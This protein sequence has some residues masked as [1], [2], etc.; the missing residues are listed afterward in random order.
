MAVSLSELD[1]A[2]PIRQNAIVLAAFLV[3]EMGGPTCAV[4]AMRIKTLTGGVP[5][6]HARALALRV[7]SASM[8]AWVTGPNVQLETDGRASK[9]AKL[10]TA[11]AATLAS[12]ARIKN[13]MTEH[14][15]TL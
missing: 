10:E 7:L 13:P 3:K 15:A 2:K 1:P 8:A 14:G 6:S 11:A 12:L 5:S 4:V 9:K